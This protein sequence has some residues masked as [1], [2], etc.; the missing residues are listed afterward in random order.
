MNCT[1]GFL[2]IDGG[3]LQYGGDVQ[4]YGNGNFSELTEEDIPFALQRLNLDE[5]VLNRWDLSGVGVGN[6]LT[7]DS[8]DANV[9]DTHV[10]GGASVNI[11][12]TNIGRK[13][14]QAAF[15]EKL[16]KHFKIKFKDHDV[17]W[18]TKKMRI[19]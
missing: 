4:Y 8:D 19:V 2:E 10:S 14:S 13:L 3:D 5:S 9:D 16:M 6:D 7:T 18:P 11:S 17:I 12:E 1:I 15:R